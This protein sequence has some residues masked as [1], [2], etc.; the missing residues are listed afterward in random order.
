MEIDFAIVYFG[1]TRSTKKVYESHINNVFNVLKKNG[2][3]YKT[4]MHTW[5]TKDNKQRIWEN[6]IPQEIDYEEYKLLTPDFY[7]IENQWEFIEN[8]NMDDFFY[9]D[10]YNTIGH[11]VNGEWLPGLICNHLCALESKKRGL[12]MVEHFITDNYK[13]KNIMFIRPDVFIHNELPLYQI[14][15]NSVNIPNKEHH[16]GLND[17]FAIVNYENAIIYG[18][19]INEIIEYRKNNGRI[20]SEKYVKYI[21][22]KYN[23]HINQINFDFTIVRP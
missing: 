19:R 8:L 9:K 5:K 20:V 15:P 2:L 4:F 17:R 10:V 1:L 16:E 13:F 18:K 6:I 14:L 23:L 3:S 11:A 12:E 21:L 22:T 7:K